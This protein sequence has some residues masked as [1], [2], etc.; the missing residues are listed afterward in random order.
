MTIHIA[1]LYNNTCAP[2]VYI[3]LHTHV[4]FVA[5]I[6]CAPVVIHPVS[7]CSPQKLILFIRFDV[8][9]NSALIHCCAAPHYTAFNECTSQSHV[10][11]F[12]SVTETTSCL[13]SRKGGGGYRPRLLVVNTITTNSLIHMSFVSHVAEQWHTHTCMTGG[14]NSKPHVNAA[15]PQQ[16]TLLI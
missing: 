13:H 5:R 11:S 1:A 7:L 14:G 2:R 16:Q 8:H 3:T 4:H 15:P 6:P 10:F 12:T 9:L